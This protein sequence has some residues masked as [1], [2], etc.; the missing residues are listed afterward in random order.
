MKVRRGEVFWVRLDPVLGSEQG[1]LRPALIIQNDV[2]NEFSPV[3][4]VAAITTKKYSREYPTNVFIKKE[5]SRL[6]QDSTVLLN[7]V[8]TIDKKRL[9]RKISSLP[10]EIM[11]K[12]NKAI[13]IS[14]GLEEI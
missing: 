2:S 1:G 4:I 7:Q 11:K 9:D 6:P 13:S 12:V 5:D 10:D 14:L 3:T 8:R